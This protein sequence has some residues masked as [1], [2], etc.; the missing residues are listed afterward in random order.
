MKNQFVGGRFIYIFPTIAFL[1]FSIFWIYIQQFDIESTRNMRQLWGHSYWIMALYGAIVGV[2]ISKKWGGYKSLLGKT[3]LVLSIGLFLQSFGQVYSSYY[4]YFNNV[5]SPPYPGIGDIGFFGSVIFYIYG[6]ILLSKLSGFSFS[7]KKVHN[8]ISAFLIS[9]IMLLAS[10][11]LFLKGYEFDW[12][13]SLT[14]FLDFGY[15]LGQAFYVS[16]AIL[17]LLVNRNVLGGILKKPIIFL[18]CA[19]IF[20][21]LSDFIFLNQFINGT[22]YVGG[23][24][25][26]MYLISYFIM[27][28]SLVQIGKAFDKINNS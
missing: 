26:F 25:D 5:E 15:P 14:I 4:V 1:I 16:I 8:K 28:I 19:L 10:Y 7:M 11:F 3:T 27:T 22:W 13:N 9:V 12:S 2:I 21:S 18:I 6:V 20:Q 24:N 23:I 17:S